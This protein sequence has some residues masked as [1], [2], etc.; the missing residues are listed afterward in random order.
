MQLDTLLDGLYNTAS[1]PT[2][3]EKTAEARLLDA[4]SE[5]QGGISE[6][7]FEDL[8]IEDLIKLANEQGLDVGGQSSGGNLSDDES[9]QQLQGEIMAHAAVN[10]MGLIKEALAS[11]L[12]R[13]CKE[14]PL[15]TEGSSICS[16]CI[17]G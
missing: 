8:P 5:G 7:P 3:L 17:Q 10:E 12:C 15:D 6:N 4:L 13:V 16:G 1:D 2:G 14:H 9:Y 11:G